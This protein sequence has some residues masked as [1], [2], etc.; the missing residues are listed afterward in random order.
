MAER[1]LV[2]GLCV[3]ASARQSG[4]DRGGTIAED[5]LGGGGIQPFG[6]RRQHHCDL[7]RGGFQTVQR[8]MAPGTE[9]G[10]AGL[11]TK[12]LDLLSATMGAIPD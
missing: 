7:P 8:G 11:A 3:L 12:G 2:Q 5:P 9:R 1:A 10:V 4:G 6:E